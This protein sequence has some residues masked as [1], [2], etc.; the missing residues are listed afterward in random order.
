MSNYKS[1]FIP[2]IAVK[3][4][5]GYK[6]YENEI[7]GVQTNLSIE[8]AI[9]EYEKL[10]YEVMT[11]TDVTSAKYHNRSYTEGFVILFKKIADA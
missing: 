2:T 10:G 4:R 6:H 7:D 1:I 5:P 11:L 3:P 8:A 9:Q